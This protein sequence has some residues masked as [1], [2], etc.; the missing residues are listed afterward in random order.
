MV[1]PVV[2]VYDPP[3]SW[4]GEVRVLQVAVVGDVDDEHLTWFLV[5][6]EGVGGGITLHITTVTP[7]VTAVWAEGRGEEEDDHTHGCSLWKLVEAGC[8]LTE[9][10]KPE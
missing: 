10:F 8:R 1:E 7:A 4:D 2:R 5:R 9:E 6:V 3:P